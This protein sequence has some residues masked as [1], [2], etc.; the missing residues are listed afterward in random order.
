MA[1]GM[2]VDRLDSIQSQLQLSGR[3]SSP[4]G[5][6]GRRMRRP[7]GRRCRPA[8][9]R[10]RRLW[11]VRWSDMT[12]T[13][14][15]WRRTWGDGSPPRRTPR[16][17]GPGRLGQRPIPTRGPSRQGRGRRT[18]A[19]PGVRRST[20]RYAG[21]ARPPSP[22]RGGC[23]DAA[24]MRDVMRDV[25]DEVNLLPFSPRNRPRQ[26]R[27]GDPEVACRLGEGEAELGDQA[28]REPAP[29]IW[30]SSALTPARKHTTRT[31]PCL[32]SAPRSLGCG[33]PATDVLVGPLSSFREEGR[34]ERHPTCDRQYLA[35]L[36]GLRALA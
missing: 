8:G 21:A 20:R 32:R 12:A 3:S 19:R 7:W 17:R 35:S 36:C 33:I 24:V 34:G 30:S 5:G 25:V 31:A 18:M 16:S 1:D 11:R 29:P 26:G 23:R 22:R 27:G 10:P 14:G 9:S 13:G 4:G 15:R 2:T 6:S 28:H